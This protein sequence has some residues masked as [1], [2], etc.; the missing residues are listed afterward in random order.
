M[1]WWDELEGMMIV[2]NLNRTKGH[3]LEKEVFISQYDWSFNW[4]YVVVSLY[5][6]EH[7][8]LTYGF[9]C[10]FELKTHSL[11]YYDS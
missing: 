2:D 7:I 6:A 5:V 3:C 8:S 1:I 11:K 4:P 9:T 10:A